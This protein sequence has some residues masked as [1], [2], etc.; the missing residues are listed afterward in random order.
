M[1]SSAETSIQADSF[2]AESGKPTGLHP[3]GRGAPWTW[4]L[5]LGLGLDLG[6]LRSGEGMGSFPDF[7]ACEFDFEAEWEQLE[8]RRTLLPG[9]EGRSGSLADERDL[10]DFMPYLSVESEAIMQQLMGPE[11]LGALRYPSLERSTAEAS[12]IWAD[13][14][15]DFSAIGTLASSCVEA[16]QVSAAPLSHPSRPKGSWAWRKSKRGPKSRMVGSGEAQQPSSNPESSDELSEI[17]LMRVS[18]C[19][20]GGGQARS[21]RHSSVHS[22]ENFFPMPGPLLTSAP[23]GLPSAM[24]RQALGELEAGSSKKMQSVLWGKG[25][26]RSNYPGAAA[27]ATA[28]TTAKTAGSLP[29][30][31]PRK[32]DIQEKKSLGGG[33]GVTLG[34]AFFLWGQRLKATP[35]ELATFP[36][37]LGVPLLG[38]SKRYSFLPL[39]PK[40]PKHSS[41]GRRTVAKKTGELEPVTSENKD[42]N[43]NAVPQAQERQALRKGWSCWTEQVQLAAFRGGCCLTLDPARPFPLH[44]QAGELEFVLFSGEQDPPVQTLVLERQQQPPGAQG[45]LRC[46]LLQ[47]E[48]DDLKEQLAVMHS[49]ADKFQDLEIEPGIVVHGKQLVPVEPTSSDP[50]GSSSARPPCQLTAVSY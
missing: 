22:R 24:D 23:H 4:G 17:Q 2:G 39:E 8:A 44:T 7:E 1:S 13:A 11:T 49:L 10:Q 47:K 43:R 15:A 12:T 5:S 30:A 9:C 38:R 16:Q 32:K 26:S 27:A 31:T 36:P 33:G 50:A 37:I 29:R 28:T 35:L 3:A 21:W 14:D 34:G 45:C 42:P 18:I 25:G 40:Q 46:V 41:T 6:L 48:V 20:K 19:S